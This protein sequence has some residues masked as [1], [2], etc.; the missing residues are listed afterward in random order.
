MKTKA[1]VVT[2]VGARVVVE[3]VE[4]DEKTEGGLVLPGHV[5]KDALARGLVITVGKWRDFNGRE[6][7]LPIAEGDTVLYRPFSGVTYEANGKK[8]VILEESEVL[9]V[10]F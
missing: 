3:K 5:Q 2:P 4:E 9:A 8:L 6:V 10:V 1:E 7:D